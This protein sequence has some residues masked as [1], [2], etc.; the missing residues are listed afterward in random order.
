MPRLDDLPNWELA[1]EVGID[2]ETKDP[3]LREDGPGDIRGDGHIAG[4][5]LSFPDGPRFHNYYLPVGHA[6]GPNMDR[7][8]VLEYLRDNLARYQGSVI[9]ANLAYEL[10]WWASVGLHFRREVVHHDVLIADTMIDENHMSYSLDA[11]SKRRGIQGKRE[12]ILRL[13]AAAYGVDPKAELWK[14][15]AEA[16]GGYGEHDAQSPIETFRRQM[17]L[18]EAEGT[19]DCYAQE[20]ALVPVLARIRRRGVRLDMD[21]VDLVDRTLSADIDDAL[22]E[23]KHVTGIALA[24]TDL[25]L[26]DPQAAVVRALGHE[27]PKTPKSGKD[28]ITNEFLD[29]INS[30]AAAALARARRSEKIVSTFVTSTRHHEIRGRLHPS[31][32]Q[33]KSQRHDRAGAGDTMGAAYGRLSCANPNIQQAPVRGDIAKAW[34]RVYVPDGDLWGSW[35]YSQ[36]EPRIAAHYAELTAFT[37]IRE[38]QYKPEMRE[39]CRVAERTAAAAAQA[40]RDD[41]RT[42]NHQMFADLIGWEGKEGR[43]NA[44]QIFLGLCYGMGSGLLARSLGLPSE[45]KTRNGRTFEVAGREAA[46]ILSEFETKAPHLKMLARACEVSARKRGYI[47]TM[48]GRKCRFP[49]NPEDTG[50]MFTHKAMNR[51]V[52]GSAGG[53]MR[54]ALIMLDAAGIHVQA[55]VHDEVDA[56]VESE[57]MAREVES[58]MI[59][60]GRDWNVPHVVDYE[61]GPTW[62]DIE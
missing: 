57:A 49:R 42:D 46:A 36:Q 18:I 17:P 12:D 5:C 26:T 50:F 19:A 34:R 32:K 51:L 59:E 24:R 40:Y 58:I 62:A 31:Y 43:S 4:F 53:M 8:R 25:T 54:K 27:P 11:V 7:E 21:Q 48:D 2:T 44:K 1:T 47:R 38:L 56:T 23:I 61:K 35:D 39:L 55:T 30:P 15:P 45:T 13:F 22:R 29:G 20:A 37:Q 3:N 9:G 10:G 52:Q 41:P 16:V 33:A 6:T 60:A 28:S 14:L